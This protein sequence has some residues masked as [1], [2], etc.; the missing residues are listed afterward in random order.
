MSRRRAPNR[1]L[2]FHQALGPLPPEIA[3]QLGPAEINAH[4]PR[5][6]GWPSSR[7]GARQNLKD[8]PQQAPDTTSRPARQPRER[9]ATVAFYLPLSLIQA[10]DALAANAGVAVS[11]IA[12]RLLRHGLIKM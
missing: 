12:E 9:K 1:E 5:E 6:K 7:G 8:Q 4:G 11:V 2:P 3:R 10:V